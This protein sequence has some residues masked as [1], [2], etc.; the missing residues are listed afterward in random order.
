MVYEDTMTSSGMPD[1]FQCEAIMEEFYR[2]GAGV[3]RLYTSPN[4][5][6]K[7]QPMPSMKRARGSARRAAGFRA[8]R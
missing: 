2:M 8:A 7:H 1:T 6:N 5:D 4:E 3:N